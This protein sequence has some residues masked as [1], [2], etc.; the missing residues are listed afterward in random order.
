MPSPLYASLQPAWTFL[1]QK[2]IWFA[3]T[4]ETRHVSAASRTLFQLA[5]PMNNYMRELEA[6]G[7]PE[8]LP[9][10]HIRRWM[11]FLANAADEDVPPFARIDIFNVTQEAN[12]YPL[13][14]D[15]VSDA[16]VDCVPPYPHYV[17]MAQRLLDAEWISSPVV[18]ATQVPPAT[19]PEMDLDAMRLS[20]PPLPA[21][22]PAMEA[23]EVSP[24]GMDLGINEASLPPPSPLLATSPDMAT[25]EAR[26]S[27]SPSP[28]VPL[29][30]EDPEDRLRSLL[31][32]PPRRPRGHKGKARARTPSLLPSLAPAPPLRAPF[33]RAVA[34][35][36]AASSSVTPRLLETLDADPSVLV[37]RAAA[38]RLAVTRRQTALP[39]VASSSRVTLDVEPAAPPTLKRKVAALGDTRSKRPRLEVA[40]DV[41]ASNF[42]PSSK[43][44]A[45]Q[46]TLLLGNGP[47]TL[48]PPVCTACRLKGLEPEECVIP[49]G[50]HGCER[51]KRN[52]HGIC[53]FRAKL[54]DQIPNF[55]ASVEVSQLSLTKLHNL[56]GRLHR[57]STWNLVQREYVRQ[58]E[59][60]MSAL[61]REISSSLH[62]LVATDPDDS[63]QELYVEDNEAMAAL[64]DVLSALAPGSLPCTDPHPDSRTSLSELASLLE[65]VPAPSWFPRPDHCFL[66][67]A[68]PPQRTFPTLV[69]LLVRSIPTPR[70][71]S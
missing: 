24:D 28:V 34:A 53:S 47:M 39:G 15:W 41:P 60:E 14:A 57:T 52:R 42:A 56:F 9:C 23:A 54:K 48:T 21:L 62:R 38:A 59:L 64:V 61:S 5:T 51:C 19:V 40:P 65:G 6:T 31:E 1:S 26:L 55:E 32:P 3:I 2:L 8:P 30:T 70:L 45:E 16:G 27:L 20:P 10:L 37:D 71:Q 69:T 49:P 43:L 25:G 17:G 18:E 36:L 67:R 33:T 68:V 66:P 7:S 50:E 29:A 35:R 22:Q 13:Y 12:F 4:P 63:F 11:W 46:F 44:L 58:S